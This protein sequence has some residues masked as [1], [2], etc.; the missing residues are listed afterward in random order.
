MIV[1]NVVS[2]SRINES[3][4]C[5]EVNGFD[6]VDN[7]KWGYEGIRR[8]SRINP[9]KNNCIHIIGQYQ[10]FNSA[11][12]FLGNSKTGFERVGLMAVL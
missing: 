5:S 3:E 9:S 6:I 12:R 8:K 10:T 1:D 4:I 2:H 11:I 7:Y